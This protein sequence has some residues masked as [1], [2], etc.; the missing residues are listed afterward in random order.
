[1]DTNAEAAAAPGAYPNLVLAKYGYGR[2]FDGGTYTIPSLVQRPDRISFIARMRFDTDSTVSERF[3]F[4]IAR[5][6]STQGTHDWF[7]KRTQTGGTTRWVFGNSKATIGGTATSFLKNK[8]IEVGGYAWAQASTIKAQLWEQGLV[9]AS[10]RTFDMASVPTLTRL[11]V[12]TDRQSSNAAFIIMDQ[13]ALLHQY[14]GNQWFVSSPFEQRPLHADNHVF[15]WASTIPTNVFIIFEPTLQKITKTDLTDEQNPVVTSG[16][17]KPGS[18]NYVTIGRGRGHG[19]SML[20]TIYSPRP[21]VGEIQY[22][23]NWSY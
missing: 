1:V 2:N 5:G 11:S 17:L 7:L 15:S 23:R 8:D 6:T 16:I 3:I 10:L 13:L 22:R 21:L 20:D 14:P 19:H 4:D 9:I 18:S 12:G